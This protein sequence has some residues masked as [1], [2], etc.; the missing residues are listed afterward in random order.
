MSYLHKLT[1]GEQHRR[2]RA[3]LAASKPSYQAWNRDFVRRCG[4]PKRLRRRDPARGRGDRGRWTLRTPAARA[5]SFA[6]VRTGTSVLRCPSD[7]LSEGAAGRTSSRGRLGRRRSKQQ[8]AQAPTHTYTRTQS[9]GVMASLLPNQGPPTYRCASHSAI[10]ELR[11]CFSRA[12]C[13]S[14]PGP[15]GT[16]A[17]RLSATIRWRRG[18]SLRA[19]PPPPPQWPPRAP[20]LAVPH[21]RCSPGTQAP[22]PGRWPAPNNPTMHRHP[23]TGDTQPC[24]GHMQAG[25]QGH[26]S[27]RP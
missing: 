11:S 25:L 21:G 18:T 9:M 16:P 27:F 19:C 2:F 26:G 8:P 1:R 23:S 14:S 12:H 17:S 20:C 6:L 5:M 13:G 3:L 4:P 15:S 7:G 10:N 24:Q 22:R